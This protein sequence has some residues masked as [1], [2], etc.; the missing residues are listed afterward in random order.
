MATDKQFEGLSPEELEQQE[1]AELPSREA[2]SVVNPNPGMPTDDGAVTIL[3][4]PYEPEEPAPDDGYA[5]I[6]PYPYEPTEP[7]EPDSTEYTLPYERPQ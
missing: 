1:A 3:P 4:Y 5:R 6:Q 2:M 7:T